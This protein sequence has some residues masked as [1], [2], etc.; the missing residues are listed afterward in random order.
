MSIHFIWIEILNNSP[1]LFSFKTV[2]SSSNA[3]EDT[4]AL[5]YKQEG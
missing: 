3:E 4:V 5:I 1:D 2:S